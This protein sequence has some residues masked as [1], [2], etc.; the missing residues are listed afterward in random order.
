MKSHLFYE[1]LI[2]IREMPTI[3]ICFGHSVLVIHQ[4]LCLD[5]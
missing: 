1:M 5:L 2:G 3:W 4:I